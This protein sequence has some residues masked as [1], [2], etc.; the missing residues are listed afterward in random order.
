MWAVIALIAATAAVLYFAFRAFRP[1][2]RS[3]REDVALEAA[4][5]AELAKGPADLTALASRIG[6]EESL[7]AAAL[8]KLMREGLVEPVEEDGGAVRYVWSGRRGRETPT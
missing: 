1:Y 5:L 4:V 7:V 8:A 3:V 2:R 6:A